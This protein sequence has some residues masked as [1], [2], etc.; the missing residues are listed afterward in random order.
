[1][2]GRTRT[3]LRSSPSVASTRRADQGP[4]EPRLASRHPLHGWGRFIRPGIVAVAALLAFLGLALLEGDVPDAAVD[5]T[6]RVAALLPRF[7]HLAPFGLLFLEES[8]VPLLMPGDVLLMYVGHVLPDTPVVW[9][10]AGLGLL[11]CTVAGASVLYA[12]AGRWG[13]RLATGRVGALLH[14]TPARLARAEQW[15]QRWGP[16]AIIFG[17]HVIGCRVPVT[18]VAGICRVRYPI[19]AL[20]VAVSAAPWIA[21][22]LALGS[23]FGG[24]VQQFFSQHRAGSLAALAVVLG[25]AVVA[26]GLRV[27]QTWRR[28]T[29]A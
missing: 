6:R 15:F 16:W 28:R 24:T 22:F 4:Q 14:L 20:S 2:I 26:I 10:V 13:R 1:M 3:L 7:G 21:L 11:F 19:F 12:I 23:A 9:L 29:T 8:G 17:R 25:V 27:A 5:A 18:I